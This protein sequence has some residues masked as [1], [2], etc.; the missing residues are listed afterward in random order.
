MALLGF[1]KS[2]TRFDFNHFIL[3]GIEMHGVYGR[4]MYETWYKMMAIVQTG[5]D[6]SPLI[7]HRMDFRDFEFGFEAMLSK[8]AGKVILDWSTVAR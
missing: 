1:Q 7:T 5:L 6:L 3:K 2:D 4:E 8:K